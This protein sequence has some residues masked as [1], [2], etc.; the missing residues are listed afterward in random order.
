MACGCVNVRVWRY[1]RLCLQVFS[2]GM[3]TSG[4]QGISVQRLEP[5][6]IRNGFKERLY[7]KIKCF[8]DF[9]TGLPIGPTAKAVGLLDNARQY[10]FRLFPHKRSHLTSGVVPPHTHTAAFHSVRSG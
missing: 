4:V 1:C 6:E 7:L 2:E 8:L 10:H 9:C 5:V 3:K